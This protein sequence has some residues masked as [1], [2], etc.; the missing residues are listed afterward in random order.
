MATG[1]SSHSR[2]RSIRKE[3]DNDDG[4]AL[5][6]KANAD[7]KNSLVSLQG[8]YDELVHEQNFYR[9]KVS[10]LSEIVHSKGDDAMNQL[11][12]KS[13]QNAELATEMGRLKHEL[14]VASATIKNLGSEREQNK[15][16][17]L[18]LSGIVYSLKSIQVDHQPEVSGSEDSCLHSLMN[19]K[20]KVN[21]VM[22]D[23]RLLVDRCQ[24]LEKENAEK[25]NKIAALEAQFH[26]LNSINIGKN[27]LMDDSE[28]RTPFP[29]I[30]AFSVSSGS[31]PSRP[32]VEIDM[33][34]VK[35]LKDEP[36]DEDLITDRSCSA[37]LWRSDFDVSA[38]SKNSAFTSNSA[39]E[40]DSSYMRSPVKKKEDEISCVTESTTRPGSLSP[41]SPYQRS[42]SMSSGHEVQSLKAQLAESKHQ[43]RQ[44]KEVC[45]T[46]FSKMK[47]VE[48][49][50]ADLQRECDEA[51]RTHEVLKMHLKDVIDQ[52]KALNVEHEQ[53]LEDL[54]MAKSQMQE[55][56]H[57]YKELEDEKR[58]IEECGAEILE[59]DGLAD[60]TERLIKAYLILRGK[61]KTL[62]EKVSFAKREAE[63]AEKRRA[64]SGRAYRDAVAKCSQLEHEMK[65]MKSR[66]AQT[67][68]ELEVSKKDTLKFKEEAKH[69]RRRLTAYMRGKGIPT[70]DSLVD[71]PFNALLM[72]ELQ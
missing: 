23:R 19:V 7:L 36:M 16:M 63:E 37:R 67:E 65:I 60:D 66:V 48:Q 55:L 72:P 3:V 68:E 39:M 13:M 32:V 26:L 56:E 8:E 33:S 10:E 34:S 12:A 43:H 52:Y 14:Q 62:E 71:R 6:R 54:E 58:G 31:S 41:M 2:G 61:M 57:N 4:S 50:F 28:S 44:F 27:Q 40:F 29:P 49:E 35:S 22:D 46:A 9:V 5:L 53:T 20:A 70:S 11:V 1:G 21:A 25:E 17:L 47:T 18:E 24:Y 69:T 30:S 59:A 15:R 64:S 42:S 51:K 45:Q 38:T